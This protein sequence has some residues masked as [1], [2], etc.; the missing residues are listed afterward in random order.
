MWFD[1]HT[2]LQKRGVTPSKVTKVSKVGELEPASDGTLDSLDTLDPNPGPPDT[3]AVVPFDQIISLIERELPGSSFVG[4][5][6]KRRRPIWDTDLD[7]LP[8]L[9]RAALGRV[10][11]NRARPGG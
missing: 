10:T 9:V 5:R 8:P 1:P 4:I 7:Q 3:A 2:F 6:P 11:A